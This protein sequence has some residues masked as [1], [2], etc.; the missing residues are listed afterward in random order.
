MGRSRDG[1][2][3]FEPSPDLFHYEDRHFA[4]KIH[5]NRLIVFYSHELDRPEHIKV[6]EMDI[7]DPDW[8]N[9][10]LNGRMKKMTTD[11]TD[12]H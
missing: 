9:W 4:L 6:V 12:E 11:F 7:G 2:T 10:R 8:M 3:N 1:L 5:N